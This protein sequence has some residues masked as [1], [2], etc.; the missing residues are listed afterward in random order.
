MTFEQRAEARLHVNV[1]LRNRLLVDNFGEIKPF[2]QL[3]SVDQN[4]ILT[5]NDAQVALLGQERYQNS[6]DENSRR[7]ILR[8]M[9]YW[10]A[11]VPMDM[12][13]ALTLADTDHPPFATFDEY[14]RCYM[15]SWG[16]NGP[17]F[18]QGY[19]TAVVLS[20]V[21]PYTIQDGRHR[22]HWYVDQGLTQ[23]PVMA[24]VLYDHPV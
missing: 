18:L 22:F 6:G 23:V 5:T 8:S 11:V 16:G 15:S 4:H 3:P 9:A 20:S 7:A 21:E 1:S 12:L 13:K 2:E 24:A 14:H 10:H 19:L 17:S